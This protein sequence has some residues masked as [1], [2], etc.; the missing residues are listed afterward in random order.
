MQDPE[1]ATKLVTSCLEERCATDDPNARTP[2]S[3]LRREFDEYAMEQ[4]LMEQGPP[5]FSSL[6]LKALRQLGFEVQVVRVA[7]PEPHATR[8]ITG[9]RVVPNPALPDVWQVDL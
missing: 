2:I 7:G 6:F 5:S 9:V 1:S 4:G 8:V 3:D